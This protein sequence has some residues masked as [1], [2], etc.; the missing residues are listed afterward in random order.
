VL[1]QSPGLEPGLAQVPA[2]VLELGLALGP[3]LVLG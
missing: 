1:G 3:V 2:R